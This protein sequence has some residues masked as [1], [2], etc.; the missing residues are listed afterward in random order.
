MNYVDS[1][2]KD[3]SISDHVTPSLAYSL[4]H[5]AEKYYLT[6]IQDTYFLQD[7]CSLRNKNIEMTFI[8]KLIYWHWGCPENCHFPCRWP[9]QWPWHSKF[10][11]RSNSVSVYFCPPL[12]TSIADTQIVSHLTILSY[13]WGQHLQFVRCFSNLWQWFDMFLAVQD[14][15]I[16]DIVT[17]WVSEWVKSLLIS[18]TSE[19]Y[20]A[21]VDTSRH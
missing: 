9:W 5:N 13:D 3:S 18:V 19:Y 15:S 16:G 20:R 14:S 4:L 7:I 1:R 21:V 11:L 2:S 12:R 17:Q 6:E 8:V 10:D